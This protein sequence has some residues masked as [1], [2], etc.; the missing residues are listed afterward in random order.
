LTSTSHDARPGVAYAA[1]TLAVTATLT[2]SAST[3]VLPIASR[4]L[5]ATSSASSRFVQGS[6]SANSSPPKR[7]NVSWARTI[8]ATRRAVSRSTASPTA[9][10]KRSLIV[11]K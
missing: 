5:S 8:D 3:G 7:P 1:P 4:T 9:C 2:P 6:S 11:L 10:P